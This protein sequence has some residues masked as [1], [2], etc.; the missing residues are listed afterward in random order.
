M[1]FCP[2]SLTGTAV[3]LARTC[4]LHGD[5]GCHLA[6][7]LLRNRLRRA[8]G[9]QKKRAQQPP[10]HTPCECLLGTC[11]AF[12]LGVCLSGHAAP[13]ALLHPPC[14]CSPAPRSAAVGKYKRHEVWIR[15]PED[16]IPVSAFYRHG[17]E[18]LSQPLVGNE[19]SDAYGVG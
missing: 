12:S 7:S 17:V 4:V 9:N 19:N 14:S 15:Q 8:A 10:H 1:G 5:A 2:L 6:I 13:A 18:S 16:Q 11:L 3:R